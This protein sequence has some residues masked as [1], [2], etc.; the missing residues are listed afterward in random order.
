MQQMTNNYKRSYIKAYDA[1]S[2]L[3]QCK[4]S[5]TPQAPM[6]ADRICLHFIYLFLF[7]QYLKRNTQLATIASLPC[8]PL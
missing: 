1:L 6:D 2:T 5:E 4:K 8:G 3:S 7:I